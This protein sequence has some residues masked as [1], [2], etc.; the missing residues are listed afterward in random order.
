M[1]ALLKELQH[2]YPVD[3]DLVRSTAAARLNGYIGGYGTLADAAFHGVP[4]VVVPLA[5][6]AEDHQRHNALALEAA[7]AGRC[8]LE[9]DAVALERAWR[10]L[11]DP[12]ARGAAAAAARARSPEGGA[13]LLFDA[14]IPLA[15]ADRRAPR[16]SRP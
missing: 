5:S 14:L 7:G 16:R 3:A 4:L 11:L 15:R 2:H 9:G 6:A 1:P 10:G 13:R 8:V 12:E